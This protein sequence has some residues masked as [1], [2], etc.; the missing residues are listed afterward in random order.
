MQYIQT[1]ARGAKFSTYY[2]PPNHPQSS[3]SCGR[4]DQHKQH[5]ILPQT[6][7]QTNCTCAQTALLVLFLFLCLS[8]LSTTSITFYCP[9]AK[10]FIFL[11]LLLFFFFFF[12]QLLFF[13]FFFLQLLLLFFFFQQLLFFFLQL[14]ILFFFFF[15]CYNQKGILQ[16]KAKQASY[17]SNKCQSKKET[18]RQ[19]FLLQKCLPHKCMH[20]NTNCWLAGWLAGWMDG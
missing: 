19:N 13:L 14:L 2:N 15:S 17:K 11:Q 16:S 9:L 4:H 12:L 18:K 20:G 8:F 1:H 10:L 3:S 7:T 5:S 6:T